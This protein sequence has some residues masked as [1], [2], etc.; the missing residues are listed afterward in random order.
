MNQFKKWTGKKMNIWMNEW[1]LF[2]DLGWG[3]TDEMDRLHLNPYDGSRVQYHDPITSFPDKMDELLIALNKVKRNK[4][5]SSFLIDF[6][7]IRFIWILNVMIHLRFVQLTISKDSMENQ[8]KLP[9]KNNCKI[10]IKRFDVV[11][12][13]DYYF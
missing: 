1:N 7:L 6:Y 4:W 11:C 12:I 10:K 9:K 2:V 13:S 5:Q 3:K 8:R